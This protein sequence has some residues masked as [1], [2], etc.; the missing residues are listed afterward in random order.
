M[1]FIQFHL[2]SQ[3][4]VERSPQERQRP[5]PFDPTQSRLDVQE[6]RGEPALFLIR[7][8]PAINLIGAL[9]QEGID[10]FEA[11]GRLQAHAE[12]GEQSQAVQR[13]ASPRTPSRDS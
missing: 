7:G 3:F 12:P 10:R 9:P 8:A 2:A 13:L 4:G 5:E 1:S 11:V 6:G